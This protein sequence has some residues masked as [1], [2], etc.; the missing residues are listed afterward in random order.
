MRFQIDNKQ[1][2]NNFKALSLRHPKQTNQKNE[3][4]TTILKVNQK[5]QFYGYFWS[6]F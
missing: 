1:Y 4:K 6:S 2:Q 3:K 5:T